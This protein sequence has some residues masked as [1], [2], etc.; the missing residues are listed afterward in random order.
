MDTLTYNGLFVPPQIKTGRILSAFENAMDW[1][2]VERF[3]DV[4]RVELLQNDVPPIKGF[5]DVLSEDDIGKAFLSG[6][7]VTADHV[8]ERVWYVTDGHHRSLAHIEADV[9]YIR[10][11][12]DYTCITSQEDFKTYTRLME[13]V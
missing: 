9:R 1:D 10:T 6:E 8:G 12:L 13:N 4:L 2:K 11:E 7:E 3:T 5:P